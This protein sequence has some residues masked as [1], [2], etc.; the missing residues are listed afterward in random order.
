MPRKKKCDNCKHQGEPNNMTARCL[1]YDKF[2]EDNNDDNKKGF[3][4]FHESNVEDIVLLKIKLERLIEKL[5]NINKEYASIIRLLYEG[6][7]KAEIIKQ[8]DIYKGRTQAYALIKKS[9]TMC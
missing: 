1:S 7:D 3:E 2:L 6:Y 8:L 5:E 9:A 4:P